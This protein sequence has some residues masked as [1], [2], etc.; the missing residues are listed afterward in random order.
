MTEESLAK[1]V[2]LV[3]TPDSVEKWSLNEGSEGKIN[4][5]GYVPW[6]FS[7]GFQAKNLFYVSS[8]ERELDV[9]IEDGE[10][11]IYNVDSE[12]IRAD[13]EFDDRGSLYLPIS[14]FG[15]NREITDISL[16][17]YKRENKDKDLGE[18]CYLWGVPEYQYELDF[19]EHEQGDA[20]GID[21]YIEE[22]R[23]NELKS[24]VVTKSIALLYVS[25]ERVRG[26]YAPWTPS[27]R[28]DEIKILTDQIKI[29][30]DDK[31]YQ[32]ELGDIL[33]PI[34]KVNKWSIAWRTN[35]ELV[36]PKLNVDEEES[37]FDAIDKDDEEEKIESKE[38]YLLGKTN[39]QL[40]QITMMLSQTK[41]FVYGVLILLTLIFFAL[42]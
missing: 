6:S 8:S 24:L 16:A 29:Q 4:E 15:T 28:P 33:S 38:E 17:V 30:S 20:I 36:F 27:I 7:L 11:D 18:A 23:F 31:K 35:Q 10:E 13:L 21:L 1:T 37:W 22:K 41:R 5:H 3:K 19:Q 9:E 14:F 34:H 26:I 2:H 32:E 42:L 40:Q 39:H 12:I 25:I